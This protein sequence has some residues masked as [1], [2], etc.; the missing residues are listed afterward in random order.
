VLA[1]RL[2]EE[3]RELAAGCAAALILAAPLWPLFS[4]QSGAS[5]RT[6]YIASTPLRTRLADGVRQF[7]MG[8]NVPA[9]WFEAIGIVL[10]LGGVAYA[11]ARRDGRR[12]LIVPVVVALIATVPPILLAATGIEDKL[13]A[14]NLLGAWICLAPVAAYG[15]TRLRAAPLAAYLAVCLVAV[16]VTQTNWRYRGSAAWA[17]ASARLGQRADG[18][19]LAV[20]PGIDVI[21]GAYYL[22]RRQQPAGVASRQLW[23]IVEPAR[24]AS[25]RGLAPVADPPIAQ[26]FGAQWHPVGELDYDGFRMI[27]LR[28]AAASTVPPAPGFTGAGS[29]PALVLAP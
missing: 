4:S 29:P 21:V 3:R 16:L 13:L 11:L 6:Q 25:Q 10:A 19:P 22:H 20:M 15:L 8:N 18:A 28:S 14:R 27:H 24:G 12:S 2:R 7:T 23:V 26:L 17:G 9:A 5:G 1:W